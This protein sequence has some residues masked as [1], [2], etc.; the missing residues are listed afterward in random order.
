MTRKQER[1][2]PLALCQWF[3]GLKTTAI[4]KPA[5]HRHEAGGGIVVGRVASNRAST[6]ARSAGEFAPVDRQILCLL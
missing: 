1:L 5:I 3:N 4:A 2:T 6:D